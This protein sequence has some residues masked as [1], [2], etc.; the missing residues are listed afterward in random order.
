VP[1]RLRTDRVILA[2][3]A[4]ALLLFG[5]GVWEVLAEPLEDDVVEGPLA[6]NLL[7]VALSTLPIAARRRAPLAAAAT[8]FG[9]IALRALAADPL[10]IY[11]PFLAALVAVYSVAAYAPA[12]SALLGARS[13]LPPLPWPPPEEAAATQLP[14]WCRP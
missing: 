2:D 3:S 6:L 10:E 11:P 5:V 1:E 7:A 8:V 14:R 12:R 9:A 13:P 4:L